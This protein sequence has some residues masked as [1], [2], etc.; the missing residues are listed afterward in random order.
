[1]T[2]DGKSVGF[3]GKAEPEKCEQWAWFDVG[4]LPSPLFG[5]LGDGA[6][7]QGHP[8]VL[9]VFEIDAGAT[10]WVAAKDPAHAIALLAEMESDDGSDED[11]VWEV[12]NGIEV[13]EIPKEQWSTATLHDDGTGTRQPLSFFLTGYGVFGCSEWP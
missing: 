9:R 1:M 5:A 4:S 10:Y 7:L 8:V 2:T 12:S 3:L 6:V 13:K 11:F